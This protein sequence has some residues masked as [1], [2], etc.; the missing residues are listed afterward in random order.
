MDAEEGDGR[1][2]ERGV[3]GWLSRIE[4]VLGQCMLVGGGGGSKL[5]AVGTHF[6]MDLTRE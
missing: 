4:A 6:A 3:H 5:E 2:E 1:E